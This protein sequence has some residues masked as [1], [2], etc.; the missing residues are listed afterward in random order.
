MIYVCAL[1]MLLMNANFAFSKDIKQTSISESVCVDLFELK[2]SEFR[3]CLH[4]T[5][6][7]KSNKNDIMIFKKENNPTDV[8]NFDKYK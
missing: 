2:S 1:L 3:R 8:N 7:H 4:K 6:Q 5:E